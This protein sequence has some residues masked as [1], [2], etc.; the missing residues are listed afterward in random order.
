MVNGYKYDNYFQN[1]EQFCHIMM[2]LDHLDVVAFSLQVHVCVLNIV[3]LQTDVF[4][5]IFK[6]NQ[7]KTCRIIVWCVLVK[8]IIITKVRGR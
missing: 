8:G 2:H 3:C 5:F 4:S 1:N 7:I 6:I